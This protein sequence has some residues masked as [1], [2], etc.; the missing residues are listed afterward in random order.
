MS[1]GLKITFLIHAIV[2]LVFGTVLYLRPVSWA[3]LVNWTPFDSDMNRICG[4]ALLA[5]SVSSWFGYRAKQWEEVRVLVLMQITLS[6][7]SIVGELWGLLFRNTPAF[8]WLAVV[9]WVAFAVA[10]IYFYLRQ[11]AQKKTLL[12]KDKPS[13]RPHPALRHG[14][15]RQ[16]LLWLVATLIASVATLVVIEIVL[17]VAG[18]GPSGAGAALVRAQYDKFRPDAEAIWALKSNWEGV[19][20][21]DVPVRLNSMGLR[22]SEPRSNHGP[23]ILF[24]G[25]SVTY[26]HHISDD[27]AIPARLE[28]ALRPLAGSDVEV[29][30]AGVPGYSTFQEEALFRR[31]GPQLRPDLVLVGFCLNDVTERYTSLSQYGGDRFFMGNVDTEAHIRGPQALWLRSATRAA[32]ITLLKTSAR[33]ADLYRVEHLWTE[34]DSPRIRDAWELVFTEMDRLIAT[35]RAGGARVAVV[36]FP[37]APQLAG[38]RTQAP[39]ERLAAHLAAKQVPAID[40]LPALAGYQSDIGSVFLDFNHFSARGSALVAGYLA[41]Q[42]VE[43]GLVGQRSP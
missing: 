31:L 35:A 38:H 19:E 41:T 30:N 17:R 36:M 2:T 22:G 4:A 27:D 15:G 21:N 28:A 29:L 10:W 24:V 12:K 8:A 13:A 1:K 33:Q 9:I 16:V 6:V 7:L 40:V 5:L 18:F 26:G 14:W 34:P 32:V 43:T 42:L 39:Q 25:D 23:R 37:Y 11:S 3:L 20:P